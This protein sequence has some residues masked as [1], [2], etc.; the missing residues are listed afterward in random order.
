MHR[1]PRRDLED[2][3][4]VAITCAP[5][6]IKRGLKSK[7]LEDRDKARAELARNICDKID[8]DSAMV[9]VTELIAQQEKKVRGKWGVDEPVPAT[10]PVDPPP[11]S[12]GDWKL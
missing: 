5:S 8:N 6:A 11:P 10:V 12:S 2:L 9:I 4:F 3:V 1:L 7:L